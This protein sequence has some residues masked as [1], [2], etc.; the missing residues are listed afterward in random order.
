MRDSRQSSFGRRGRTPA[1]LLD[2]VLDITRWAQARQAHPGPHNAA[3]GERVLV[4][5][6]VAHLA[7]RECEGMRT[8]SSGA[9][10]EWPARGATPRETACAELGNASQVRRGLWPSA[11][12]AGRSSLSGFETIFYRPVQIVGSGPSGPMLSRQVG[13]G[14]A[15]MGT[16]TDHDHTAGDPSCSRSDLRIKRDGGERIAWFGAWRR[17]RVAPQFAEDGVA[18]PRG[19]AAD[20]T[21]TR[22]GRQLA[23]GTT[24]C[25]WCERG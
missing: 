12:Q 9:R 22:G 19:D 18:R 16:S 11:G 25:C 23:H 1:A 7:L 5:V 14:R 15:G 10:A 3:S 4:V 6:D 24:T 17:S 20:R 8:N 21:G 2:V 13:D